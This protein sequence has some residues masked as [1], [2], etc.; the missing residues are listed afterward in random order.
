MIDPEIGITIRQ[1]TSALTNL[2]I[3]VPLFAFI[4]GD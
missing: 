4:G 1:L 3:L 2:L